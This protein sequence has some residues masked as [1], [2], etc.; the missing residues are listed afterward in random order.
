MK[1]VKLT[2]RFEH[3]IAEHGHADGSGHVTT[4]LGLDDDGRVWS[5]QGGFPGKYW[6]LTEFLEDRKFTFEPIQKD[7]A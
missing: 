7:Q 6:I 3:I 2:V 4:I 1:K 5:Y